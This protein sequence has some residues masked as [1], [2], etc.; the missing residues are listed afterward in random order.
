MRI[1]LLFFFLIL[2]ISSIS[3]ML[4]FYKVSPEDFPVLAPVLFYTCLFFASM[5]LF[6]LLGYFFRKIVKNQLNKYMLF[7]LSLRQGFLLAVFSCISAYFLHMQMFTWWLE[8]LVLLC[9]LCIE[10][11]FLIREK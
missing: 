5:S 11:F 2:S 10:I 1:Y 3:M 8:L 7:A 4:I 6:T 9:L